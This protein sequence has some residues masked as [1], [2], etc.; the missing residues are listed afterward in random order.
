MA[1]RFTRRR[2]LKKYGIGDMRHIITV[3]TRSLT[4]PAFDSASF[5]ETYDDGVEHWAS[6]ETPKDGVSLFSGVNV[7][8][9]VTDLFII[10]YDSTI[11]TENIVR[12]EGNAYKILGTTNP[13]R[14]NQY[15]ELAV[16]LLGNETLETNT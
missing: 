15:L 16:R 8:E 4:P 10:R 14:R 1:R 6:V 3:H 12:W 7:P 5:L 2:P 9:G 13:D 11:T